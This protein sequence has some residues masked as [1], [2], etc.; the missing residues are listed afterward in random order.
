MANDRDPE[1]NPAAFLG[2][3][4]LRRVRLAAGITSQDKLSQMLGYDQV[5]AAER[6]RYAADVSAANTGWPNRN[7]PAGG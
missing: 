3:A 4:E 7:W 6:A 5:P 1:T 2:G